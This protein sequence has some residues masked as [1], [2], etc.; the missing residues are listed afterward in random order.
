MKI[1]KMFFY[2]TVVDFLNVYF[3]Y[4]KLDSNLLVNLVLGC[5]IWIRTEINFGYTY[6]FG[7]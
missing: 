3:N 6:V 5:I 7:K 1:G 4:K 2:Y